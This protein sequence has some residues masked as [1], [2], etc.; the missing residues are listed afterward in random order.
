MPSRLLFAADGETAARRAL[1]FASRPADAPPARPLFTP[2]TARA[3]GPP[4]P[5]PLAEP[6]TGLGVSAFRDYLAC[7]YR[8]YLRH[9]LKLTG[10][11]D[12]A[13][14]MDAPRFGSLVHD[15]L[16]A[17]ARSDEAQAVDAAKIDAFLRHE[18]HRQAERRYGPTPPPAV[19]TQV[20]QAGRRLAVFAAWQAQSVREGWYVQPD[21]CGKGLTAGLEVDGEPFPISGSP[22]R[23]DCHLETGRYRIWDYKTGGAGRGPEE[24]HRRRADGTGGRVWTDLQLPLYR[25]LLA[26]NGAAT[27]PDAGG[28][29]LLAADLGTKPGAVA[30]WTEE[31]QEEALEC[32]RGVVRA[33]RAGLF[34][35]PADPPPLPPA[36]RGR[37]LLDAYSG[38]CLDSCDDRRDWF[39][40]SGEGP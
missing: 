9:V 15:C 21:L 36:R 37:R 7:P 8:F 20:H 25:L 27:A 30:P 34:W 10:L 6:P 13:E 18:L 14:E 31:D 23:V 16:A 3:L 2:G 33:I 1:L 24:K 39:M 35:P 40:V 5:E 22:D 12:E 38:L 11:D 19:R 4:P 26:Q 29:V 32:A 17:F 28:Y